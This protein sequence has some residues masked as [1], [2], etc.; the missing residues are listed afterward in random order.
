MIHSSFLLLFVPTMRIYPLSGCLFRGFSTLIPA[1]RIKLI[2]IIRLPPKKATTIFCNV[3]TGTYPK[4]YAMMLPMIMPIK[5]QSIY[6]IIADFQSKWVTIHLSNM[7]LLLDSL[8]RNISNPPTM[9]SFI[10]VTNV[11]A[12]ISAMISPIFY[13]LFYFLF[14]ILYITNN[15]L[16]A[17]YKFY[18]LCIL[19][20]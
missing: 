15:V 12:S 5:P 7:L 16:N 9:L 13:H 17:V 11:L 20:F 8:T 6:T 3:V 10:R 19:I 14:F 2:Y 4:Q 18:Y 1:M